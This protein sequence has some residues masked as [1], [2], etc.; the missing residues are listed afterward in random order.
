MSSDSSPS[1]ILSPIKNAREGA[2]A[3]SHKRPSQHPAFS[4]VVSGASHR[5]KRETSRRPNQLIQALGNALLLPKGTV[6]LVLPT[7]MMPQMSSAHLAFS[8][9]P[10]FYM[11]PAAL[12]RRPDDMLSSPLGQHILDYEPPRGFVIPAFATFDG[13]ID[14][15]DHMLHYN[16][17]MI[18]NVGNNHLLC[19]EF[20]TS[21]RGHALAQLHKL[22]RNLINSF[23]ELLAV[24]VLQYLCSV[25]QNRNI[26]SLQTILK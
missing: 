14:P 19:K 13:V 22:L 18:L 26:N 12:I 20:S 21:L 15:Y 5:A 25:G 1:L 3:K 2:K 9:G 7:S 8:A 23:S 17:A 10:T 24:F 6:P 4:D 11:P 16:Q